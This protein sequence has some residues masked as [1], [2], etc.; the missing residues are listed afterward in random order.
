MK[1]PP[2]FEEKKARGTALRD[3]LVAHGY[4][5]YM[6]LVEHV[7]PHVADDNLLKQRVRMTLNGRPRRDA[8]HVIEALEAYVDKE[9]ND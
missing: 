4:T 8:W 5:R 7:C 3:K 6:P 1:R 2:T 9:F